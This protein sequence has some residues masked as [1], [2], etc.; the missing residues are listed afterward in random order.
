M[1]MDPTLLTSLLDEQARS[2][3][4]VEMSGKTLV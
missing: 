3:R 1:A 4:A 2:L